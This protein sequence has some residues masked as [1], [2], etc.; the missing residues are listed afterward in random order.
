M[1]FARELKKLWNMAVIPIVAGV[2]GVIPDGLEKGL[3]QLEI[4]GR[5]EIIQ[6][7]EI[8]KSTDKGQRDQ[9]RLAVTWTLV[10]NSQ[11][12]I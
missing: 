8:D 5:S 3:E 9:R 10:K 1:K 12:V 7:I 2:L 4:G 6:I 11:G